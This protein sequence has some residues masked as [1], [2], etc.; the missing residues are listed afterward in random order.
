MQANVLFPS[1]LRK[2]WL[3]FSANIDAIIR[4][5]AKKIFFSGPATKALPYPPLS[6]RATK[7][8]F[9]AASLS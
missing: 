8:I 2:T 4:E 6:G 3:L 5:A 9:F 7:K 1:L